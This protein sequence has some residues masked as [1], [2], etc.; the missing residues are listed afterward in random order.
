MGEVT[1]VEGIKYGF[2]IMAYL[3][4]VFVAGTIVTFLG[5][6]LLGV[7]MPSGLG[8]E[9]N[10]ALGLLGFVLAAVGALTFYAGIIGSLYKVIVDGVSRAN[11]T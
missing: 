3:L 6:G 4:V 9:P 5:F 7:A 2:R 11:R 8:E 10:V 1:P